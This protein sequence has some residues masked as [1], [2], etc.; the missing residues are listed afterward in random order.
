MKLRLQCIKP[1]NLKIMVNFSSRPQPKADK[2]EI[3][4]T[5]ERLMSASGQTTT[6]HVK[7]H[8]RN[9]GFL[10]FQNE[11]SAIMTQLAEE[12]NWSHFHN[13][14]FRIYSL[15]IISKNG[16]NAQARRKNHPTAVVHPRSNWAANLLRISLN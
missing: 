10:A 7:N 14:Q 4:L 2:I 16:Q 8:L 1:S 3:K 12:H 15:P 5:A 11:I 6:L 9:R 13:G